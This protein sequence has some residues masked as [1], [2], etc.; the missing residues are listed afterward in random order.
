M[1]SSKD[2]QGSESN[3]TADQTTT[4]SRPTLLPAF[5]PDGILSSSPGF[6]RPSKRKHVASQSEPAVTSRHY[7][8]PMP[9][10]S[11]N[12]LPSSPSRLR[13]TRP[14]L[15]RAVSSVSERVPLGDVPSLELPIN[16]EPVLLGRSGNSS[17]YQLPASRLI[18]RVH[19]RAWYEAPSGTLCYGRIMAEC[20]GWNGMKIHK[21]GGKVEIAKGDTFDSTVLNHDILVE[22]QDT[23]IMLRWPA[24]ARRMAMGPNS[25]DAW[26]SDGTPATPTPRPAH[27][28]SSPPVHLRS[29]V[30]PSPRARQAATASSTFIDLSFNDNSDLPPVQVYEDHE[31]ADEASKAA[32]NGASPERR[33][34]KRSGSSSPLSS[35]GDI[36][37]RDEENDPVVHSFGAFGDNLLPRMAS[38]RAVSPERRRE[39]L[40]DSVSPSQSGSFGPHASMRASHRK[41]D[42]PAMSPVRNHVINQLAFSRLHALPISSI[43]N[44]LPA[45]LK[46]SAGPDAYELS[47]G[48]L[49]HLL[50]D[51][52]CVG[53]I[54]REGKDAAGK[55]LENEFYYV[56]E[57]DG[58]QG[59]RDAVENSLGK[60]GLRAV[61]KQHKQYF[62]KKPRH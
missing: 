29:P 42:H 19:V 15:S 11:T 49:K 16:G 39:P 53:Q 18:S 27:L 1:D 41:P 32:N 58:D 45:S 17:T 28:P 23:R 8:T 54:V 9:T 40:Q 14:G 24:L 12:I 52:P 37:D 50:D 43:M 31:S 34:L 55:Q 59:R 57:M 13:Q 60:P 4:S 33:S 36:S 46:S 21:H 22:I 38:F 48:D 3:P 10:S 61:R 26:G 20:V 7:P 25:E 35:V 2:Q 6:P 47:N 51:T 5:E 30:S 44:N 56:P 62:W